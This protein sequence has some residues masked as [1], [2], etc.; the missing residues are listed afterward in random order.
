MEAARHDTVTVRFKHSTKA[1][2]LELEEADMTVRNNLAQYRLKRALTAIELAKNIGVSRQ[3]I[4][5]M[6]TGTYVPNTL[7]AL[8]LSQ[9][10]G[11]KV[12]DLFQIE[13]AEPPA[14]TEAVDLL[15]AEEEAQPGLPVQLCP[16]ADRLVAVL[17][18]AH[19]GLHLGGTCY[20][21]P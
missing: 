13:N 16:V 12:E 5:A 2:S 14:H 1:A 17:P 11:V 19:M 9:V 3:T 20:L 7:L 4:Y 18:A 10:L 6:E 21:T 8:K 15:P